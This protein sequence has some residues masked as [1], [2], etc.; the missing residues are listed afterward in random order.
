[1]TDADFDVMIYIS[2]AEEEGQEQ[3]AH[4]RDYAGH[5]VRRRQA[6]QGQASAPRMR[7]K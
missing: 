2:A 3:A 4:L 5:R 1:V 7:S 6:V